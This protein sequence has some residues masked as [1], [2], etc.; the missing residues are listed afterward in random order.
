MTSEQVQAEKITTTASA[1]NADSASPADIDPALETLREI[2]FSHYRQQIADLEAE[3]DEVDRRLTNK[4]AF[5]SMIAP[6]LGDAIR[7][8]IRDS[9][10]EMIEVLYPIIGQLVV[11]AVSEAISDLARRID[12]QRRAF[13]LQAIGRRIQAQF[14]GGTGAEAGLR[15]L[16]PFKIVEI[17]LIH[18]ESGLLLRH[19][20]QDPDSS[21]D[22]D[23]ISGMLTAIRDFV[24]DSFGRGQ[25][26]ELDEIQYGERSILIETARRAYLAVVVE[27]VTPPGFRA[28]MREKIIE[29]SNDHES[30][31]NNYDGDP[32]RL[33]PAETPLRTLTS[34][35]PQ[36]PLEM[37]GYSEKL[38]DWPAGL[39]DQ[40]WGDCLF[41]WGLGL[42]GQR[43]FVAHRDS[44][45]HPLRYSDRYPN[46]DPFGDADLYRDAAAHRDGNLHPNAS[47]DNRYF[48]R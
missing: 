12:A 38:S 2:L 40:L 28:K 15:E 33:A 3:L 32:S 23:L 46:G 48:E 27:G 9:R 24:H 47:A 19:I 26:S 25:E 11:R 5:I 36:G 39:T 1:D 44:H 35:T 20:S 43:P 42:A 30:T 18:R 8:K 37:S 7:Q 34:T 4:D 22:S 21:P 17:F 45:Q 31:L 41:N 10:D 13:S 29:I 6:I 14:G 16:L